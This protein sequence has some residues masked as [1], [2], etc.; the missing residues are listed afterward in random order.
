MTPQTARA[1]GRRLAVALA[2]LIPLVPLLVPSPAGA[3]GDTTHGF[4]ADQA[5]EFI[6]DE[7]LSELLAANR[8]AFVSGA[9]FP[10]SGYWAG[11][12]GVPGG[13]YGEI[14]HWERFVNAY[15]AHIRAKGECAP[16]A[17]PWGPCAPMIAHALGTAAHGMGDELWDWLFEPL[18]TD[19][20]E[21]PD[22]PT[23]SGPP[24][25][26]YPPG[27]LITSIEYAMDMV[28]IVD[29][30]LW[31]DIPAFMPPADDL[32]AVYHAL[33]RDDI[34][35]HGIL[36]GHTMETAILVAE[37]VGALLDAE[38][39]REQMPWSASHYFSE[40]GGV[41]YAAKG[42][43]GYVEAVW[44]KITEPSH[45]QPRVV[46]VHPEPGEAGV[47]TQWLPPRT[48]PGPHT[49]GGENRVLASLS[50]SL[51]ATTVA[52]GFRLLDP[53]G[54]AVPALAGY[55]KA[56]PYGAADGTHSMLFYPAVNLEPCTT[57]TAVVTT[58]LRD[59]AGAS[60]AADHS[61]SFQTRADT[62][63]PCA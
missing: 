49:G 57:Y 8:D 62:G 58:A 36:V 60:L 30:D 17:D 31:A 20:G 48:S 42:I 11:G 12:A 1:P 37:R 33:G 29:H 52:A 54:D 47:P 40:S 4:M 22:H 51:D 26:D 34:T 43:A 13:D 63:G 55:P 41:R 56:G 3:A 27:S 25:G 23:L 32:E 28:A 50:N 6:D 15:A 38:R 5:R 16:L 21:K 7:A 46:A 19:H 44:S 2:S 10:D 61:W 9:H 35:A 59:H 45:P 39:V 53:D 24:L 14:T 18:V